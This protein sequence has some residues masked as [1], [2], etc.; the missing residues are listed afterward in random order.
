MR[1]PGGTAERIS[2]LERANGA[3]K[4]L[5]IASSIVSESP[6]G[7]LRVAHSRS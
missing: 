5:P 6:V 3:L 1:W 7:V 2:D 4:F